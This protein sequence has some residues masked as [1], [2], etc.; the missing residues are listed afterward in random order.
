MVIELLVGFKPSRSGRSR[1][2]RV[3]VNRRANGAAKSAGVRDEV[4]LGAWNRW[5]IRIMHRTCV[6]SSGFDRNHSRK[7]VY[8]VG[9]VVR[10]ALIVESAVASGL[11]ATAESIWVSEREPDELVML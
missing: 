10:E 1:I 2:V 8:P 6:Q 11:T 7:D 9:I 5:Q 4:P 3:P